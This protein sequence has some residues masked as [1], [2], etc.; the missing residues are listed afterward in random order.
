MRYLLSITLLLFVIIITSCSGGVNF[1][2]SPGISSSTNPPATQGNPFAGS[3]IDEPYGN[4]TKQGESFTIDSSGGFERDVALMGTITHNV[5]PNAANI[6]FD[7]TTMTANVDFK[8]YNDGSMLYDVHVVIDEILPPGSVPLDTDNITDD[9]SIKPFWNFGIV[10]ESKLTPARN[11]GIRFAG[12]S[13][14]SIKGHIE[15]KERAF[16]EWGDVKL[17]TDG[18]DNK[19]II[20]SPTYGEIV[21]NEVIAGVPK[22][23]TIKDVYD[24]C[25]AKNLIPVGCDTALGSMELKILDGRNPEDVIRDLTNDA[26]LIYP[27]VNPI[28]K[29]CE[30][31]PNEP[32]YNMSESPANYWA[33]ER[34]NAIPVWDYY[35][36][37]RIDHSGYINTA[38]RI[39]L[40]IIDSGLIKHQDFNLDPMDNY[41]WD[42]Y[43][44]NFI[45]TSLPPTDDFG[46]GTNVAGIAGAMGNNSFGMAGVAWNPIFLP[47][48]VFD[49]NGD[50]Q[51][52]S[53][54]LGLAHIGQL[55]AAFPS[56]R[57]IVNMSFVKYSVNPPVQWLGMAVEY[58]DSFLNTALFAAAGNEEHEWA[59]YAYPAAFDECISVAASSFFQEAGLDLE[60][61]TLNHSWGTN[62]GDT[63]DL[64]AP[65][66]F[67]YTTSSTSPTD[68]IP[69]FGGTSAATPFVS[70]AAAL[71]WS[72]VPSLTKTQVYQRIIANC[73]PM[74]LPPQKV[75]KL[76]SGRLDLYKILN[77]YSPSTWIYSNIKEH[78]FQIDTTWYKC[79][80]P[81]V[82]YN[83]ISNDEGRK[84]TIEPGTV[85]KFC[86]NTSLTINGTLSAVG[87]ESSLIHFTSMYDDAVDG[88]DVSI[89]GSSHLPYEDDWLGIYF[90]DTSDDEKCIMQY[91]EIQYAGDSIWDGMIEINGASPTIS[92]CTFNYGRSAGIYL[93]DSGDSGSS[94]LMDGNTMYECSYGIMMEGLGTPVASGNNIDH[95]GTGID[96]ACSAQ[97]DGNIITNCGSGMI[98]NDIIPEVTNNSVSHCGQP[99]WQD[100]DTLNLVL[101]GQGNIF[102]GNT[103]NARRIWSPGANYYM[104]DE[105][106]ITYSEFSFL[107]FV[108][109]C[110]NLPK[111]KTLT[112]ESGVVFKMESGAMFS[113]EGT[114]IANG[115][116]FTSYNDDAAD[117]NDATGNGSVEPKKGEWNHFWFYGNGSDSVFDSCRVA[118]GG[119]GDYGN[120]V[121]M[122]T[123][124]TIM[125]SEICFSSR[126]GIYCKGTSD[127][128]PYYHANNYHDNVSGNVYPPEN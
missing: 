57:V 114:L 87:T 59:D 25:A 39:V 71:I 113:V 15:Y 11:L 94:P 6:R 98:L 8:I 127:P 106:F 73:K 18:S 1:P 27:E 111:G 125:N 30:Q 63:V 76:G 103:W 21:S 67:I 110:G 70:G 120:I 82:I 44:K 99:V 126:Y 53:V 86:E 121:C 119:G 58:V 40:A 128:D 9:N 96:S 62:W 118:Y 109:A 46:H 41:I 35:G 26:Y 105:T 60:V 123:N 65:G 78:V 116:V 68:F 13:G 36:D 83:Q 24:Y 14:I 49:S 32:I 69:D 79:N 81:Y 100:F 102:S 7:N 19:D 66:D 93:C 42:K 84:F 48:K 37:M 72:R 12:M 108:F 64:C 29:T 17:H 5:V 75:G 95:C 34:I 2:T 38:P 124:P 89:D 112:I 56:M 3:P 97:I 92:S 91:C 10:P 23:R 54:E 90:M 80:S 51:G 104:Q 85:V 4:Y 101:A 50:P 45:N 61:S 55:A 16:I 74:H 117:N 122:D 47:I 28:F 43:G 107:P 115:V 77:P 88:C 31:F 52:Y 22:D 33:Y 20:V